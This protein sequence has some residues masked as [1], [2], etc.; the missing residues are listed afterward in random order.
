MLLPLLL[1]FP[2]GHFRWGHIIIKSFLNRWINQK[3]CGPR[4]NTHSIRV[5]PLGQ[6]FFVRSVCIFD[7]LFDDS[8][9]LLCTGCLCIC[10]HNGLGPSCQCCLR[11]TTCW[12]W[13]SHIRIRTTAYV[14]KTLSSYHL[15][16][17]AYARYWTRKETKK[18]KLPIAIDFENRF[19]LFN[20]LDS[21]EHT[22]A[23]SHTVNGS[24]H[25]SVREREGGGTR[26]TLLMMPICAWKHL[27]SLTHLL[28]YSN[29]SEGIKMVIVMQERHSKCALHSDRCVY[30][31]P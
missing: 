15:D 1:R 29:S 16:A 14:L 6:V 20:L 27:R 9:C 11:I 28:T 23:Y 31:R 12:F 19:Y 3:C 17:I 4:L 8:I 24:S 30:I 7:A 25:Y 18:I 21:A 13:H 2:S 26:G 5:Y 22:S 10:I